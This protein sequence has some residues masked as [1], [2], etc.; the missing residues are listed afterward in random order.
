MAPPY[1]QDLRDR[2]IAAV[3]GGLSR[4]QAA[5]LFKIGASTAV[6]WLKQL[7]STGSAAPKAMGGDRRS[8]LTDERDW[9]LA[10]VSEAPDLTLEEL[11]AELRARGVV[12]G[13]GTVWRFFAGEEFS[14]KKNRARQR[15]RPARRGPQACPLAPTATVS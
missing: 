8:R 4:R 10:R 5:E 7:K 2:V 14:F 11:R 12:V 1:S 6:T 15:T 9:L 3:E 13:Y